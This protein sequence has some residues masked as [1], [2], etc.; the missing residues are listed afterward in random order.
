[1][2]KINLSNRNLFSINLASFAGLIMNYAVLIEQSVYFYIL[3]ISGLELNFI[4]FE[5][6]EA[7]A[8]VPMEKGYHDEDSYS[9]SKKE[10]WSF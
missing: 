9:L 10:D 4:S 3:N 5:R 8:L 1:M 2:P 7:L 6:A